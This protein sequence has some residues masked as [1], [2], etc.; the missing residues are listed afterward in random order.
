MSS[1]KIC[2]VQYARD[3]RFDRIR[4]LLRANQ[5]VPSP[6][7]IPFSLPSIPILGFAMRKILTSLLFISAFTSSP[8]KAKDLSELSLEEKVGQ[9]FMTYFEGQEVNE[10]AQKTI[11]EAGF[12]GII[13]YNW[14]NDLTEPAEVQKLSNSLQELAL[15]EHGLPL[16]IATDQEGGIVCRLREGFTEFPGNAA[17][18][19]T[20]D[21]QL[22]YKSA[23]IMGEELKLVGVNF[24]LAPVVDVNSNPNNPIIGIRAYHSEPEEVVRLAQEALKGYNKAGII[25]CLKHFPGHGDVTIDSHLGQ[26]VLQKSL[27]EIEKTDLYP[28][29]KLAWQAPAIMNAHILFPALDPHHVASL[30]KKIS[31]DLLRH[32][33]KFNGLL[34]SDSLTMSGATQGYQD[35]SEVFIQAFEAG[36]DILLIGGRSLQHKSENENNLD[37]ILKIHSHFLEAVRK[38]RISLERLDESVTRILNAKQNLLTSKRLDPQ[39]LKALQKPES[40][41]LAKEIAYR[42]VEVRGTIFPENLSQKELLV[43]YPESLKEAFSK[44]CLQIHCPKVKALSF[45]G[46]EPTQKEQTH[47]LELARPSSHIFFLSVNAWKN[48]AQKELLKNLSQI[49]PLTLIATRDPQDLECLK[50]QNVCFA[51]Y[52][53]TT[54]SIDVALQYLFSKTQPLDMSVEKAREIGHL[55][56]KNECN[57]RIDQLTFWNPSEPFASLGIG[58]FIW[59]AENYKGPFVEGRFHHLVNFIHEKGVSVPSWIL[60]ARYCPWSSREAFYQDFD[61]E[62][63][64]QLRQFLVDTTSYQAMYMLVRLNHFFKEMTLATLPTQRAAMYK[65]FFQLYHTPKGPYILID[66]LNFKHE[67]TSPKERYQGKG[68]G[69]LQVLENIDDIKASKNPAQAFVDS[70]KSVLEERIRLSPQREVEEKW[71]NGWNNRLL[72]YL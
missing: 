3:N 11:G 39:D 29:A 43:V 28:F 31:T 44:S 38:G 17:L 6:F 4:L 40:I 45:K 57:N 27:E 54:L 2:S 32:K 65:R 41:A 58:H 21:S 37:E 47:I 70:A 35:L 23:K 64:K 30:S 9:V 13:Y 16:F 55:I 62:K 60:Q 19:V 1:S 59:P 34:I 33:L 8:I 5:K 14:A 10:A 49:A 72:S 20:G 18:G 24:N 69:L 71:M 53:P 46:L 36:N 67:G 7:C 25:C 52:S 51:T 22:A 61:S 48:S 15:K 66:Y 68:W 63:M 42:S 56:W 26:P 50:N 12:G